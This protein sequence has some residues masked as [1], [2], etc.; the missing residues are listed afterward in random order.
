MFAE[1]CNTLWAFSA[2]RVAAD[3]GLIASLADAPRDTK[4]LAEGA[5]LHPTI[6]ERVLDVLVAYG[7]LVREGSAYALSEQGRAQAARGNTLRADIA[8]TFG[9]TRA[10]VE[11]ARRGTLAPGWRH[12]DPEVIRSQAT[13]SHDMSLKM[14]RPLSEAWPELAALLDRDGAVIVDIGVGGAGGAI[15]LC[16][17]FAKL[18]VV[19]IDP[20]PIALVE[21]RANVAANNFGHRIE[22]R[23]QRGDELPDV[24]AFDAA[25]IPAKFMDDRGLEATLAR[26]R[27][28]L[29]KDGAVMTAAWNEVGDPKAAA[30]SRLRCELWG[31]GPRTAETVTKMLERA[32]FKDIRR[33]PPMGDTLPIAARM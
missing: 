3:H 12:N 13:L 26:L 7:L 28:A 17:A 10:L 32:G 16:K 31:A 1:A 25:F 23:A 6:V 14:A 30:V 20:L 21:A 24:G 15:G 29:K 27:T 5:G 2:L 8:V 11:E 22:L 9:Q 18:R 19:G 4:T 33:G